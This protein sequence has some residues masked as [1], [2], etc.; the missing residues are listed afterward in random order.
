MTGEEVINN[1]IG[2][3]NP[4]INRSE[5]SIW[6]SDQEVQSEHTCFQKGEEYL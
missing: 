4:G 6:A 2:S 1:W 5:C 3:K